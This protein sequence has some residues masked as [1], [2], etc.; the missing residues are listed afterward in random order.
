MKILVMTVVAIA[1][2]TMPAIV[3]LTTPARAQ[4]STP[5][6]MP[7]HSLPPMEKPK[8]TDGLSTTKA[9]EKAYKSSLD[10]IPDPKKAYDPWRNMRGTPQSDN[11]R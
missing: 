7:G 8:T 5:G 2:L 4:A 1:L 3:L 10:A 11:S 9:D 6:Q